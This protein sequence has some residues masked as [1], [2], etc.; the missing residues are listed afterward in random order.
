MINHLVLQGRMVDAPSC[1]Q[2]NGGSDFA[3]FRI[4]WN[5]K[6]KDKENK[7]FLECKS[8]G[9]TAKFIGQYFNQ[10]GTEL[11]V[12]GKLNT[13]EWT[14]QDGQKRSKIVLIVSGVHFCGKKEAVVTQ[15]T[16]EIPVNMTPV[17]TSEL[18]F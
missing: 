6:Y 2:T 18:P 16:P 17:E 14:T 11:A 15:D 9:A 4:A 8:F 10:K 1:G 12:E 7:L 13:E 3:N 5:E